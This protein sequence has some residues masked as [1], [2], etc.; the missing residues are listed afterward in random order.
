MQ[1]E[2]LQI[3]LKVAEFRS[4]TGAATH[5][6]ISKA[7]A[8]AAVKRVE[9][10]L[11]VELFVRTTRQLRLSTAGERYIPQCQQALQTLTHAKEQIK[12]DHG[13]VDGELRIAV[14]SDLG[15]NQIAPWMEEFMDAHPEVGVRFNLSDTTVDL[16]RDYVDIAIRYLRFGALD[17]GKLYGFKLCNVP[18][19]M[20]ATPEYIDRYGM[21]HH[22][23]ELSSHNGLLYQL[24]GMTNDVW[25]F[26]KDGKEYKVKMNSNRVTNDGDLVRRWCI[27]GKG[28]AI[29]SCLVVH[30]E[31]IRGD[32]VNVMP[33]FSVIPAELWMLF[34]SRQVISPAARLLRD[35][36]KKK[37]HRI[38]K[39]LIEAD[40]I[41]RSV[42]E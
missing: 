41:K 5:L 33:E 34:P 21:P 12:S 11:G 19:F 38:L 39:Q 29:K 40:M 32:L 30:E 16:F 28:L 22:P 35:T 26:N 42:L 14:S 25:T 15:R 18:Y 23:D 1:L 8:S 24:H 13:V 7:T 17:D 6:D 27:E 9:S 4:I 3:I 31:L 36:L 10:T 20:C 37:C 2:D